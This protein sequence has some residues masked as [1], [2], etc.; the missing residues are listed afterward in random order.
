MLKLYERAIFSAGVSI[1][2]SLLLYPLIEMQHL[3]IVIP[4]AC[5][6]LITLFFAND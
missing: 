2:V 4:I 6:F 3:L 5:Y 1:A